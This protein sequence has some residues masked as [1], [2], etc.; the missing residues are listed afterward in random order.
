MEENISETAPGNVTK[1]LLVDCARWAKYTA[2]LGMISMVGLGIQSLV[3]PLLNAFVVGSEG[4]GEAFIIVLLYLMSL[5]KFI[6]IYPLYQLL[7]FSNSMLVAEPNEEKALMF[8]YRFFKW[9]IICSLIVFFGGM[10]QA[11]LGMFSLFSLF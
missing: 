4:F 6:Y 2:I 8:L 7:Q 5:I 9:F 11:G 10:S 3:G 1:K